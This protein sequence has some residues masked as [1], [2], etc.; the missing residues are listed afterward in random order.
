MWSF[1]GR[2]LDKCSPHFVQVLTAAL[3]NELA[4]NRNILRSVNLADHPSFVRLCSVLGDDL[5]S[6]DPPHHVKTHLDSLIRAGLL[7]DVPDAGVGA[8]PESPRAMA[9][10]WR[11]TSPATALAS[12]RPS[13]A[14][15]TVRTGT[16]QVDN[17]TLEVLSLRER[18]AFLEACLQV[19]APRAK[20]PAQTKVKRRR[21]HHRRH[22]EAK[23][24]DHSSARSL[25]AGKSFVASPSMLSMTV[26]SPS[27]TPVRQPSVRSVAGGDVLGRRPS[28]ASVVS[29]G[30][31]GE[32]TNGHVPA[33]SSQNTIPHA[34]FA[35]AGGDAVK[36][37]VLSAAEYECIRLPRKLYS[38][39]NAA[40][41]TIRQRDK[42]I[43]VQMDIERR[44]RVR[45]F[46]AGVH[47]ACTS[48]MN[49]VLCRSQ[50]RQ[51]HCKICT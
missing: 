40:R 37:V 27:P 16:Q 11:A 50:R 21:G 42:V 19:H 24:G 9:G 12:P 10:T 17:L 30:G 35:P 13:T 4:V 3:Q 47:H 29:A 2:P 23:Q 14:S 8:S 33:S 20:L 7:G 5:H 44:L 31:H 32:A 51:S 28:S 39:L 41:E 49:F 34:F 1:S 22:H 48:T 46:H 26:A 36:V 18:V 43:A 38:Q 15:R 45:D 25:A 6:S